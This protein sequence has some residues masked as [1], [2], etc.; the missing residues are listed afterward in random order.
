MVVVAAITACV[1]PATVVAL[2]QTI[3]VSGSVAVPAAGLAVLL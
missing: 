3:G 2:P 1:P